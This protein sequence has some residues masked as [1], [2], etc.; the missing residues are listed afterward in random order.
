RFSTAFKNPNTILQSYTGVV[1]HVNDANQNLT[2]TYTVTKAD[3]RTNRSTELGKGVVPPNNQ[4]NAT[5][6]YNQAD[7]G[8]N[9]ARQ[10]VATEGELD[11]YTKEAITQLSNGYVS[12]AGQR[13]DGFYA[14]I[15]SIF[16][17][18]KLRNPG[19]DSQAGFNLHL[20]ALEIPV[21]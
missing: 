9:P 14:D 10:G 2:Q 19:K 5:P 16:D 3:H 17:L 11:R 21:V 6:F 18:L 7:N 4:G 13:D 12:F 8:E 20:M 1:Q 15:Q